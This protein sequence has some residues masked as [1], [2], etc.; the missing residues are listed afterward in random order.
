MTDEME[1]NIPELN[2][3]LVEL[4]GT[5]DSKPD[6][7]VALLG[8]EPIAEEAGILSGVIVEFPETGREGVIIGAIEVEELGTL[9]RE[10]VAVGMV[11]E[12]EEFVIAATEAVKPEAVVVDEFE[13]RPTVEELTE[14]NVKVGI[15]FPT[16]MTGGRPEDEASGCE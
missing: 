3:G 4:A 8:I 12:S 10:G 2:G 16:P 11:K 15:G 7:D 5:K 9:G 1:V 13:K 6:D 14:L